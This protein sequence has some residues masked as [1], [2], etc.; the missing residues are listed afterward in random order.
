[1]TRN[2]NHFEN[3]ALNPRGSNETTKETTPTVINVGPLQ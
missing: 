2:N 3:W 1:M